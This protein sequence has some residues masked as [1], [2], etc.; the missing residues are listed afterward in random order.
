MGADIYLLFSP[1]LPLRLKADENSTREHKSPS[2]NA[3]GLGLQKFGNNSFRKLLKIWYT[4][5]NVEI[6][7]RVH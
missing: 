4:I 6:G 7:K 1:T 5:N 3:K 2:H